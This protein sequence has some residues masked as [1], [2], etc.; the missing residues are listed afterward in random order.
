MLFAGKIG[1]SGIVFAL[2]TTWISGPRPAPQASGVNPIKEAPSDAHW[3]DGK[4]DIKKTQQTLQD[5]GHY[6]GKIDGVPG[7]RMRASIRGFQKAENL[8]VTGQLDVQTADR[9]GVSPEVH[10]GPG[11]ESALDKPS[12]G[13]KW[14]K[15][16]GRTSRNPPQPLKKLS[17]PRRGRET[18]DKALQ[19]ENNKQPQ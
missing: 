13:I 10:E 18:G 4:N 1:C 8:P 17:Q 15:D 2:L 16:S 12:A 19:A 11:D 14:A 9:L 5:R 6:H 3:N 7:L